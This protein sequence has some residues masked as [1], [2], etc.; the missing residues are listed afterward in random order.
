M[1]RNDRSS[2]LRTRSVANVCA[3]W[4]L[5]PFLLD[6]FSRSCLCVT[7]WPLLKPT[8][9][10]VAFTAPNLVGLGIARERE[11]R[12][13]DRDNGC[14]LSS[15]LS[16]DVQNWR[17]A[18]STAAAAV[19]R[20]RERRRRSGV[21]RQYGECTAE[22]GAS[23]LCLLYSCGRVSF[24]C[25]HCA[26]SEVGQAW[27][28][29]LGCHLQSNQQP[30][31]VRIAAAARSFAQRHIRTAHANPTSRRLCDRLRSDEEPSRAL[32]T[33]RRSTHEL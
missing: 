26:S 3:R 4:V 29:L 14:V 11:R 30:L 33:L 13:E 17:Y 10:P 28:G 1:P 12:G 31:P 5:T 20:K 2:A 6:G 23:G 9:I 27:T 18:S 19:E 7:T 8:A 32:H 21:Q 16:G 22:V 24:R 15:S 25:V